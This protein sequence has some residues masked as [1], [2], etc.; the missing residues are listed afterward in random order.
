MAMKP[1]T[2]RRVVL[3][4]SLCAIMLVVVLGYFVVRP[5]QNQRQLEAM[6]TDGV[7]AYENGDYVNTVKLLG[8]YTNNAESVD[9]ELL[10]MLARAR[11][12]VQVPDGGHITVS[13][14]LY[15]D[16]L[17]SAPDDTEASLELL[18]LMNVRGMYVEARSLAED[19]L[20]DE[21]PDNI[22]VI[23]ELRFALGQLQVRDDEIEPVYLAAFEH[24]D[25]SYADMVT[26][27]S[28]LD[29]RSRTD[30]RERLLEERIAQH[31]GRLDEQVY[32]FRMTA[33]RPEAGYTSTY[34][35]R[36][37]CSIIGLDPTTRQWE[38]E[39]PQLSSDAAWEVSRMFNIFLEPRNATAVMLR[40]ALH[41]EDDFRSRVYGIRSL[42]WGGEDE[43]LAGLRI[44]TMEG[45]PDPDVLGYRYLAALR[46]SDQESMASIREQL[47]SVVLDIRAGAW[48]NFID[49]QTAF[50][51]DDTVAARTAGQKA[52]DVYRSE[53]TFHLL[54]GDIQMRQGRFTE[55]IDLWTLS[56]ELANDKMG[57]QDRANCAGWAMPMIRV[58]DAY[59][60]QRRL[61]EAEKYI[62]ELGR[63]GHRDPQA[64]FKLLDAK[65]TLARMGQ[66]SEEM[67]SEFVDRWKTN[68][69]DFPPESRAIIAPKV[70]T[71]LATRG[72]RDEAKHELSSAIE[73]TADEPKLMIDIID[74]DARYALGVAAEAGIDARSVGVDTLEGA[75]RAADRAASAQ[76]SIDAGLR[77]LDS[78]MNSKPESER[79]EWQRARVSFLDSRNDPRAAEGWEELLADNPNDIELHY[80]AAE[81]RAFT[82]DLEKVN[83]LIDK[84][85]ELTQTSGKTPPSRLRLA[86][87]NAIVGTIRNRVNRDRALE[88]VR[89][90]VSTEP[91]N[92]MARNMLGRLLSLPPTPGLPEAEQY[93]R[94]FQGAID[95]YTTLA[96]Q[97]TGQSA[98]AYLLEASDLAFEMGDESRSNSLLSEFTTRFANDWRALPAA[99]ERYENLGQLQAAS[100]LYAQI[101]RNYAEPDVLLSYASLQFRLDNA[102]MGFRVLEE[103][104]KAEALSTD[105]AFRLSVLY[106]RAGDQQKAR[107]I[108]SNGGRFG[109]DGTESKLLFARYARTYLSTDEQLQALQ[110]ATVVSPENSLPWRQLIQRLIE[111]GRL[112]EAR[113]AYEQASSL[114]KNDE[115]IERL[116]LLSLGQ[117]VT[118]DDLLQLPGIKDNPR[119][120]DAVKQVNTYTKLPTDTPDAERERLLADLIDSYPELDAV[121]SYAV[122]Q[123]STL[124]VDPRAIA[125]H[126]ERA[127]KNAK[128]NTQVMGIAGE[129]AVLSNQPDL[130][131]RLV[132]LWR[133]NSLENSIVAEAITARAM[134]QRSEFRQ[135]ADHLKEYIQ[136]VLDTPEIP[137]HREVINAY[138]FAQLKIGEDPSVTA[139][140]L[141]PAMASVPEIRN[142]VWLELATGA[143]E[144]P[145]IGAAWITRATEHADLAQDEDRF[146]LGQ[147]WVLLAMRHQRWDRDY[148]QR[149]IDLLTPLADDTNQSTLPLRVISTA[150]AVLGRSQQDDLGS[151]DFA[152]AVEYQ[153]RAADREVG[154]LSP[155]LEAAQLCLE[156]QLHGQAVSI[157]Q[158]MLNE[159]I[160]EGDFKAS[161]L[162]NLAMATLR[163]GGDVVN[164]DQLLGYVVE[165]TRMSPGVPTFWGTRGWVELKLEDPVAA[166]QS[167]RTV[168]GANPEDG[169]G[170]TGLAI[171]LHKQGPDQATELEGALNKL[172]TIHSV[173][174]LEAEFQQ[175]LEDNGL[176]DWMTRSTP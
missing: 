61:A 10:L 42:Y 95:Q 70:A 114:I 160:P 20:S 125:T 74:V 66:L 13:V 156:A 17:R 138:C 132:Q 157:Y 12:K 169:E 2:F 134:I 117:T 129:A 11:A 64:A 171:A 14:N 122:M 5:W 158:R 54:M 91:N 162:N 67:G 164:S 8:R 68:L 133:A 16:Y 53:P 166:E 112:E 144:D 172:Q 98:Q 103:I 149:A 92:T 108:A 34:A 151:D 60:A 36:E 19:L 119:L 111:L 116:G 159:N 77:V 142:Q 89:S 62:E 21:S 139:A 76:Q 28:Y 143:I 176:A 43:T 141:E 107:D 126:A 97:L 79:D 84:I 56:N 6:R 110:D 146:A 27:F 80:R 105:Q 115:G 1:R 33:S 7:A 41:H 165:S 94:D 49:A 102:D 85:T 44:E 170:W 106:A 168:I 121:Q 37:L 96:R 26:Y 167:F 155:L 87:A 15:R 40:S 93:Q 135:A 39:A 173:Q 124:R 86:R 47:D 145:D 73:Y 38:S 100:D 130:A 48:R 4:G 72:L 55:A 161:L 109:L 88:I 118:G 153:L 82:K 71:I 99:A 174:P 29:T 147:A 52:V 50:R 113:A 31:P 3:L 136:Q 24:E 25:S 57:L 30:E 65:S 32:Q 22:E 120:Q 35:N 140:R 90:V 81:S 9:P 18:P 163:L 69:Q 131:L 63:V 104:S 150:Y 51:D 75:L 154:N 137:V 58:I 59:A 152:R 127:L 78:A 46:Q 45:E 123:M 128:G 175:Y 83:A 23:R 148:A 101:V